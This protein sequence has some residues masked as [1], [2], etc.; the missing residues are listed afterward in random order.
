MKMPESES[1]ENDDAITNDRDLRNRK[2]IA[3]RNLSSFW[4]LGLCNNYA[5]VIMLSAAFDI[6]GE[7]RAPSTTPSPITMLTVNWSVINGT[8]SPTINPYDC[9]PSSTAVILLADILPCLLIKLASPWFAD[10]IPYD[11]RIGFCV[12]LIAAGLIMVSFAKTLALTIIGVSLA[13]LASGL[14]EFSF[15]S[16]ATFFDE[17]VVSTWSSGTGGAGLFGALSYAGLTSAGLSPRNTI[18]VMLIIPVLMASSYWLVLVRVPAIQSC[19]WG[20]RQA[21]IQ[22]PPLLE[23]TEKE[24]EDITSIQDAEASH[25]PWQEKVAVLK[26]VLYLM[27]PLMVVYIAEYFINQ[28]LYEL[29]FFPHAWLP[30]QEQYRWYQVLYQTGVFIS[31][32]S[33]NIVHIRRT[34]IFALMQI[35][36]MIIFLT[37]LFYFYIPSIFIVFVLVLFEGLL[38]GAAYVNTFYIIRREVSVD[39]REFALGAPTVSDSIGISIAALIAVPTHTAFCN[40]VVVK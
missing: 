5:Y 29:L 35:A 4:L 15:L 2:W 34:W 6:L 18:L 14:G 24:E 40:R 20:R 32:S 39:K 13:S 31:R 10:L 9:N 1:E 23:E 16:M 25:L 3:R 28:G 21:H 17:N 11:V 7:E 26:S 12:I 19:T 38:G 30:H 8:T 33:V 36:N 37:Q 22:Y 27:I